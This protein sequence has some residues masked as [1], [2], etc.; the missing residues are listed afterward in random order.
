VADL[1]GSKMGSMKFVEANSFTSM[2]FLN[3]GHQFEAR[4]LPKEAQFAPVFGVTVA[5]FNGD[6]REDLFLGQN[7]FATHPRTS[8]L[9]AGR[10]LLLVGDGSGQFRAVPGQESG[11]KLYGEQRGTAAADYDHDG[12]TDLAVSQNGAPTGLFRNQRAAPGLRVRLAGPAGNPQGWGAC[13]RLVFKDRVGPRREWRGGSGYWSQDGAVQVLALPE[14]AVGLEV[15]WPGGPAQR[16]ALPPSARSIEVSPDG[17][18]REAR[19]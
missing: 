3:R 18:V 1:C 19:P 7:F 6:G 5:D 13:A 8:R 15:R 4:P 14:A 2:V 16:V 11:I 9:D 17:Q 12:R 10:G